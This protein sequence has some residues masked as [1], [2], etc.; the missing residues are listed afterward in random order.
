MAGFCREAVSD[1]GPLRLGV[2]EEVVPIFPRAGLPARPGQRSANGARSTVNNSVATAIRNSWLVFPCVSPLGSRA[3]YGFTSP[4]L[5][6]TIRSI[7]I[8][9]F[10]GV[11]TMGNS[12]MSSVTRTTTVSTFAPLL[13]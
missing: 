11:I 13:T 5:W 1:G 6:K 7:S 10:F 9:V 2:L 12:F 8:P 3:S 4:R